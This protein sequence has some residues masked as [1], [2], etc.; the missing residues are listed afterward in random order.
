MKPAFGGSVRKSVCE[1]IGHGAPVV[2]LLTPRRGDIAER[3]PEKLGGGL[4]GWKVAAGL[5]D[6]PQPGMHAFQR[7]RRIEHL[8]Y[9]GWEGEERDDVRPG[10]AAALLPGGHLH[11]D[12]IGDGADQ[13]G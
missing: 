13:I 12:R 5:Q 8:P 4:V 11:V 6:L 10:A 3:Q 9:V 2:G 1:A 7:I